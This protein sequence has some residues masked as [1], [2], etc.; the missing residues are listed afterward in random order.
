MTLRIMKKVSQIFSEHA[1]AVVAGAIG[2]VSLILVIIIFTLASSTNGERKV[3]IQDISGSAFILKTDGQISADRN[4]SLE[5]GDVLITSASSTVKL[6][7]DKDKYIYIEPETTLYVHY[8]DI[9][10]KGSIIVN[11]SEGAAVCRLDSKLKGNAVF[12]VRTPNSVVS[13]AGTV[14]RTEF[15]Y[16]DTYAGLSE[17]KIT[18]VQ[19]AQG[20]V[21]IQLYDNNS[22]PADQL[23]LLAEGKSARMMTSADVSRFEYLN[24]DTDI[25]TLSEDALKTF[26]RIAAERQIGYSLSD[27]NNAYQNILNN[28]AVTEP[29]ISTIY[30]PAESETEAE[31][32][33]MTASVAEIV[34][35]P[36]TV[37]EASQ[38]ETAASSETETEA[39]TAVTTVSETPAITTESVIS[40]TSPTTA[41]YTVSTS[42]P[43]S[44]ATQPVTTT[45]P[46]AETTVQ[47]TKTVQATTVPPIKP[48]G[49]VTTTTTSEQT[50]AS[51]TLP[52]VTTRKET[53][54]SVP[55]WEIINSAALTSEN[56]AEE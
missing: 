32:T 21:N 26:I 25:N 40:V 27:L 4:M 36:V 7:A 10:E 12:E 46:P 31:I 11:I 51:V 33:G 8:T 3:T 30:P 54:S 47:T 38:T 43:V 17:V 1:A 22:Q 2:I 28:G 44:S 6:S 53:E 9:S 39:V 13:A 56:T 50:T 19:C 48:A 14:F 35:E 55:W 15:D 23:M 5:S 34:T 37:T 24:S 29:V 18:E 42:V 45:V 49:T 41:V 16:Y 52:P 20:K